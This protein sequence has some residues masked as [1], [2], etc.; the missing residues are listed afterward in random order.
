MEGIPMQTAD[1][2]TAKVPFSRESYEGS[3]GWNDGRIGQAYDLISA[4]LT[5]RGEPQHNHPLLSQIEALDQEN[6]A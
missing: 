5:N 6:A 1:D 3:G 4:V 2:W